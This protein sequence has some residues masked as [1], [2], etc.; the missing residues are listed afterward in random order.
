MFVGNDEE[1]DRYPTRGICPAQ[2]PTVAKELDARL[3]ELIK[4]IFDSND[5]RR[6]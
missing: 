2:D 1:L 4:G 5:L 6:L 3:E